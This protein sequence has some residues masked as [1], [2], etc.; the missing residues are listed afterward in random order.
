[1]ACF[2][3]GLIV[4]TATL[5]GQQKLSVNSQGPLP[6]KF[7]NGAACAAAKSKA[8]AE[9]APASNN[10]NATLTMTDANGAQVYSQAITVQKFRFYTNDEREA[11]SYQG[12]AFPATTAV[13]T[14]KYPVTPETQRAVQLELKTTDGTFKQ[15]ANLQG[16][17]LQDAKSSKTILIGQK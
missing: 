13:V 8:S 15:V 5:L 17:N 1:M 10:A 14:F 3:L 11:K 7:A 9:P 6:S 2:P 12:G 4:L 16:A